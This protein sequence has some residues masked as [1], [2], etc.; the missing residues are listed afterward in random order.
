MSQRFAVKQLPDGRAMLNLACG[1][2]MHHGWNNLDFSPYTRL[3]RRPWL[4]GLLRAVGFL[5]PVR[6]E[7]LAAV[8]PGVICWDL[9]HGIPFAADTFDV[10]YSSHF[11]EH[12]DRDVVP[13]HLTECRRVIKPGGILRVVVPD[14]ESIAR[15]YVRAL[16]RLESG[17][18]AAEKERAQAV[19]ELFDQMVRQ[20]ATG[21]GEQKAWVGRVERF[22]RGG[23]ASTGELH[24]WMY[25]RHSLAAEFRR[26]GFQEAQARGVSDS[27]VAGWE[28]F[29]LDVNEDGEEYKP[30]S[31]YVEGVR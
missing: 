19:Y 3:A 10:V 15:D 12:L 2:K 1:T 22:I 11:V 8:D 27:G 26:A 13:V 16:D 7:R 25:D 18:A 4:V 28:A 31:L 23:A 5:S 24:R 14:L 17:E 30:A 29:K 6:Q 9:R 20:G 21:A